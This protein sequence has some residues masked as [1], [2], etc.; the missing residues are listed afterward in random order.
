[1]A[2]TFTPKLGITKQATG[3]NPNG[4]WGSTLNE[5]TIELIDQA[6]AGRTSVDISGGNVTLTSDPGTSNQYRSMHLIVTGTPGIARDVVVPNLQKMYIVSNQSDSVVEV[7]TPSNPGV[8]VAAGSRAHLFVNE[9][10]DVVVQVG[11]GAGGVAPTPG[12]N[13]PELTG[14]IIGLTGGV[15]NVGWVAAKQGNIVTFLV[16]L[17]Q[18]SAVVDDGSRFRWARSDVAGSGIANGEVIPDPP[19]EDFYFPLVIVE[20]VVSSIWY[21]CYGVVMADGSGVEFF[22]CDGTVWNAGSSRRLPNFWAP[23]YPFYG[24]NL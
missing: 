15:G 14:T 9:T 23:H 3:S 18:S 20:F 1:M 12:F 4:L 5:N 8:S 22:K 17:T 21:D 6:I 7:K 2:N 24:T 16:P 10:L 19:G 11:S 13:S